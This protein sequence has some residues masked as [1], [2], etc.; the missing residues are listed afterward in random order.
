MTKDK[1]PNEGEEATETSDSPAESDKLPESA[2]P[3]PSSEDKPRRPWR[4]GLIKS[5]PKKVRYIN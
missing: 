4:G 5:S 1:D 2:R 3:A